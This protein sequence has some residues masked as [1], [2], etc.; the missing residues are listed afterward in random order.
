MSDDNRIEIHMYCKAREH[1]LTVEEKK[2]NAMGV[3]I[4]FTYDPNMDELYYSS[5]PGVFPGK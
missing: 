4:S 2:R 5:L 3:C 1:L